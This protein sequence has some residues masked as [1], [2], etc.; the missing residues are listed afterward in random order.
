MV[1]QIHDFLNKEHVSLARLFQDFD[2]KADGTINLEQFS[3][4]FE[5]LHIRLNKKETKII[6]DEINFDRKD[7]I[8]FKQLENFY[9]QNVFNKQNLDERQEDSKNKNGIE[10]IIK[11][12][13][14]AA[15]ENKTT[16]ERVISSGNVPLNSVASI[17]VFEKLLM[18]MKCVLKR[19][20]IRQ[21]FEAEILEEASQ[22]YM[23]FV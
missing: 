6:F 23:L 8:T 10:I 17:T 13:Q 14:D 12:M 2:L 9:G 16:L 19:D 15:I 18:N 1:T 21:V 5:F 11:K 4:L 3:K 7:Y 20:E 22:G